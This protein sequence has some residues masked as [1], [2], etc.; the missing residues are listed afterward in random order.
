M[1]PV[2]QPDRDDLGRRHRR[3]DA[4]RHH[5]SR[6]RA[7]PRAAQRGRPVTE[8]VAFD[9]PIRAAGL[10]RVTRRSLVLD[11]EHPDHVHRMDSSTRF[12]GAL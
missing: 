3:K 10:D 11:P 5:R 12:D 8:D 6:L 2:V 7:A 4:R 9:E 1:I